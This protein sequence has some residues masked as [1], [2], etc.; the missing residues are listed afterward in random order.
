MITQKILI[1]GVTGNYAKIKVMPALKQYYE[2]YSK[3]I[4][5]EIYGYSRSQ[6][7]LEE[8]KNILGDEAFAKTTFKQG[9]Y[10]D[11]GF[12]DYLI[13]DLKTND[14]LIVYLAV[15]PSVY[16]DFLKNSCPYSESSIDILI[17]KPFGRSLEEAQEILQVSMDCHL[18]R[19]IHFVD[20]Y[21]FKSATRVNLSEIGKNLDLNFADLQKIEIQALE[22]IDIK[23]R[24]GYYD[25][26][27]AIKDMFP[28]LYSLFNHSLKLFATEQSPKWQTISTE[29]KQYED[30]KTDV[31]NAD[32]STETYFQTKLK[33]YFANQVVDVFLESG[34]KQNQKLTTINLTLKNDLFLEYQI[35]PESII[36]LYKK[37]KLIREIPI[38]ITTKLDHTKVF[39][40][41]TQYNFN[42]FI[43][44]DE[45]LDYW[46]IYNDIKNKID[47]I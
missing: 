22:T 16:V 24:A 4:N 29:I 36:K 27:G 38:F 28:H 11:V 12:L 17:E 20:H 37:G 5:I 23:D 31:N 19:N 25:E 43:G 46:H 8:L 2:F 21:L 47:E 14:R 41:V 10:S 42:S 13:K 44:T 1:F 34:K 32:S 7:N 33:G 15:P 9:D 26:T 6:P 45:I 39:E 35:A 30:Y 40:D 18:H 3:Q